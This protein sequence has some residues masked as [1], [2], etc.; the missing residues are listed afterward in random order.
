MP[1][2]TDLF[3]TPLPPALLPSPDPWNHLF[4]RELK[5]GKNETRKRKEKKESDDSTDFVR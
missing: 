2:V 4:T 1:K 5:S 3:Q